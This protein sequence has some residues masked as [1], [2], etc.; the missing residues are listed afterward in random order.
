MVVTLLAAPIDHAGATAV[1]PLDRHGD[2]P[3]HG[4]E[5]VLSVDNHGWRTLRRLGRRCFLRWTR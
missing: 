2:R 1:G 5:S 3:R 4:L